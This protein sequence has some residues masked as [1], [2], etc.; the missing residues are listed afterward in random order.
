MTSPV[1]P[2][3]R[4]PLSILIHSRNEVEQIEACIQTA[5]GW[6]AEVLVCDMASTDGT[7]ERATELGVD[8]FAVEYIAEFDSARNLSA[9]KATQ[10]WIL[11]LDADERLT[12]TV[13]ETIAGLIRSAPEDVSAFNIP[14][15]TFSFGRWIE[16]AGRWWP[17]YKSPPLLRRGSFTFSGRVHD[18]AQI[19]GRIIKVT[20]R[21][22]EDA[23]EHHSHRD[24]THYFEKL[25]RYTSLEAMKPQSQPSTWQTAAEGLGRTF[26]W[27]FD[28]TEGTRDGQAGFLL[29]FGSAVYDTVSHLK[30]LEHREDSEIP[31]SAAEFLSVALRAAQIE[32]PDDF[33]IPSISALPLG[34]TLCQSGGK[35]RIYRADGVRT[36]EAEWTSESKTDVRIRSVTHRGALEV[37]GG[38]EVQLF[39]SVRAIREFGVESDIGIGVIPPSGELTHIYSLHTPELLGTLQHSGAPYV[40]SPIYWDRAELAWVTPRLCG[41]M[42]C[43][44]TLG[45]AIEVY[46]SLRAEASLHEGSGRFVSALPP[47]VKEL[48]LRGSMILPNAQREAEKLGASIGEDLPSVQVIP[49]AAPK[50]P[51]AS[52]V[53]GLPERPFVACVGRI[54][55]N[56]NQLTLILASRLAGLPLVLVGN[57]VHPA[58]AELCKRFAGSD[59]QFLGG[60]TPSEVAGVLRQATVHCLPSFGETPGIANLEACRAGCALVCSDRGAEI[61]YFGDRAAYCDPLDV[62]GLAQL[63]T[64]SMQNERDE[65]HVVPTW[66]DAGR[67]LSQVYRSVLEE[68]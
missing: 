24:L 54:E 64:Q 28:E 3:G 57:E 11:Y 47:W 12:H 21:S 34:I 31:A 39:E 10:P 46:A 20:P 56:K 29:A 42:E 44:T 2:E 49:N 17:S 45:E 5:L 67:Q 19:R 55:P 13:K 61:E 26:A 23:I 37:F 22:S 43:A 4:L 62:H 59:T 35:S 32:N 60:R 7:P 50:H 16:H 65:T 58:Y 9:E 30:R 68:S 40:L 36:F 27:Y 15:R 33:A 48:V 18:P 25:N 52:N 38:G 51:V 1:N 8:V 63:L 41:A 14:F 66:E 6:A 53:P